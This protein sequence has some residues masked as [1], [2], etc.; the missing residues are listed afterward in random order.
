VCLPFN[1]IILKC[2]KL[3]KK[4]ESI[5]DFYPFQLINQSFNRHSIADLIESMVERR[6]EERNRYLPTFL[7]NSQQI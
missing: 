4:N 6:G 1:L 2:A 3:N 5:Q 7:G